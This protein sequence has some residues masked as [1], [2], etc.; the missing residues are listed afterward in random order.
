MSLF[1]YPITVIRTS[2][3]FIDGFWQEAF[4]VQDSITG[5]VQPVTDQEYQNLP[6]GR[7]EYGAVKVYTTSDLKI[8]DPNAPASGDMILHGG[9]KW[10][11]A[12][13]LVYGS[14]LIPHNKYIAYLV[15]EA[16]NV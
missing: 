9:Q 7:K 14:G 8:S 4:S 6:E 5:T 12:Q 15:V 16:P 3:A 1:A 10:E 11:I 2:G 13:K